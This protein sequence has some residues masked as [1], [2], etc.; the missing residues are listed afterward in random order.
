MRCWQ[1][2]LVVVDQPCHPLQVRGG[3][4]AGHIDE[5]PDP[6]SRR[7]PIAHATVRGSCWLQAADA[8]RIGSGID[9]RMISDARRMCRRRRWGTP[10]SRGPG[11]RS[12]PCIQRARG[13]AWL[14]GRQ[15]PRHADRRHVLDK[16][17][18]RPEDLCGTCDPD[19]EVIAGVVASRVVVQVRVSLARRSREQH[20]H[21]PDLR[22]ESCLSRRWAKN[23]RRRRRE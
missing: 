4:H 22:S 19:V 17:R 23:R 15:D 7:S 10:S 9:L 14:S 13:P 21:A 6:T 8:E 18:R 1:V 11:P 12:R 16:D 5:L 20:V 2:V 3:G